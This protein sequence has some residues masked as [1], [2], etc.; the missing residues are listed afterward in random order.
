MFVY[1]RCTT[2]ARVLREAASLRHAG[3]EVT[4]FAVLDADTEPYERLAD[5]TEIV[6]INRRPLHYRLAWWV[7]RNRRDLR[8]GTRRTARRIIAGAYRPLAGRRAGEVLKDA[9]A[10]H[11]LDRA[12]AQSLLLAPVGIPFVALGLVSTVARKTLYRAHKPLMY[13]DYWSRA[14]RAALPGGY[15]VAHAHDLNTLPVA[16]LLARRTCARLLYDSHE[17]YPEVS[18]LSDLERRVWSA[19][20][21]ILIRRA[22]R[23]IT[24]CDSIARELARR[25][26]VAVPEVVLNCPPEL[27]VVDPSRSPLRAAAGLDGSGGAALVLYQGGFAPNRGLPELVRAMRQ[28]EGAVLV[29]MGWGRLQEELAALISVLDLHDRVVILPPVER[30]V[31]HLWTAGA[32][33]GTIPYQPVGLNNTFA[34]P[35]KLFEYIAAG[36]PIAATRLPEITRI[37]DGRGLGVTFDTV[38]PEAIAAALKRLLADRAESAQ[39]RENELSVRGEYI[40]ERQAEILLR[41]YAELDDRRAP[42]R[43]RLGSLAN[44]RQVGQPDHQP[45]VDPPVP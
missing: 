27:P 15:A 6:R 14:Y 44:R 42:A 13:L 20:E 24:V 45:P 1:N 30:T 17:L 3:H 40:W 29:L 39:M 19:I 7:R 43:S 16:A 9:A 38:T 12:E 35:N 5:G 31:L 10:R 11:G 32:D 21:P 34:T 4:I 26:R 33:I 23:V 2:D 18:T 22:D 36:V 41:I 37:V 28:V 25:Y 8:I